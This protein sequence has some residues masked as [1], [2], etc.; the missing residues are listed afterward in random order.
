[1][2]RLPRD[3]LRR[4]QTLAKQSGPGPAPA[5]SYIDVSKAILTIGDSGPIGRIELSRR[6]SLGEGA[7]RTILKHMTRAKVISTVKD[8]CILTKSGVLLYDE[9]S[10]KVS[11]IE[12]IDAG[13][14][15]LD[16]SNAAILV[17][18]AAP[19][20]KRG[21]EQRDAAVRAGATGACTLIKRD[22]RYVMPSAEKADRRMGP[23]ESL[24]Q[25][26]E[27]MFSPSERDVIV[28][29]GAASRELAHQGAM[30]AAL[31]LV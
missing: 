24:A 6:L 29:V 30:A 4:L 14:L 18:R 2:A 7:I 9:L 22:R 3:T 25:G 13:S 21:I 5:F 15:S 27:R 8:G 28:I 12:E 10:S 26:L 17:R 11:R 16:K 20:V 19:K 31:T 23:D 1:V